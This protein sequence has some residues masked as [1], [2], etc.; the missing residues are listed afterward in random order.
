MGNRRCGALLPKWVA[1]P[2]CFTQCLAA[3][4]GLPRRYGLKGFARLSD[5]LDQASGR[6]PLE[7][8]SA[9]GRAYPAN[10]LASRSYYA[11]MFRRSIPGFIPSPE[12]YE[13]S[14]RPLGRLADTVADCIAAGYSAAK[15]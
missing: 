5:A 4:L 7:R 11:V 14:L 8:L 6:D 1:P 10:A 3:K 12:A 2:A 9:M 13:A 15:T